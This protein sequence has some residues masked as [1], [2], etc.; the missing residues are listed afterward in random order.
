MAS[1]FKSTTTYDP[2]FALLNGDT[3]EERNRLTEKWRDHKL[4]ELNF[5]GIVVSSYSIRLH[6]AARTSYSGLPFSVLLLSITATSI[7]VLSLTTCSGRSSR[8]CSYIDW[9]LAHNSTRRHLTAMD[10][11]CMLVLRY[12]PSS[13]LCPSRSTTINPLA[14]ALL[15]P[16]GEHQHSSPA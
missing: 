14:S 8:R 4:E 13:C 7:Y 16:R 2:I 5:V 3:T 9:F 6:S 10:S 1:L 11:S 12:H 15:P